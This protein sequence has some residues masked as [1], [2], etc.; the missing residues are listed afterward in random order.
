[1]EDLH[2]T[3]PDFYCTRHNCHMRYEA[4][5]KRQELIRTK[6]GFGHVDSAAT[7]KKVMREPDLCK[8]CSQGEA[9]REALSRKKINPRRDRSH[10]NGGGCIW[11]GCNTP[12][13]ENNDLCQKHDTAARRN[14]L[15][16]VNTKDASSQALQLFLSE[17]VA[18]AVKHDMAME[19]VAIACLN[20]GVQEYYKRN[21]KNIPTQERST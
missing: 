20:Q 10:D 9:A 11:P 5:V 18:I 21:P 6:N 16:R 17:L 12:K 1:M 7:A 14:T 2:E 4:C 8:D 3:Q 13:A 19:D 15:I